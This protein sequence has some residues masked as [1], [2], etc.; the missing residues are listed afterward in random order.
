MARNLHDSWRCSLTQVMWYGIAHLR[1]IRRGE[2]PRQVPSFPSV[3]TDRGREP[4]SITVSS[5]A[6]SSGREIESLFLWTPV[7]TLFQDIISGVRCEDKHAEITI[8]MSLQRIDIRPTPGKLR[9]ALSLP[10]NV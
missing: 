3:T 8:L 4:R 9:E 10:S 6:R 5:W 2:A 7:C 1:D